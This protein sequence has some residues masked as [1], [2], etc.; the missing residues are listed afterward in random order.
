MTAWQDAHV[1]F[2]RCF[3]IISR[4]VSALVVPMSLSSSVGTFGGG[5]AGGTPWM[6]SRMNVPRSTGDVRF[7]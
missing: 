3:A 7:G 5:F 1:G 4:T 6:C 2:A